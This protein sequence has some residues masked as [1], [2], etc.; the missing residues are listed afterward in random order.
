MDTKT[1]VIATNGRLKWRVQANR[2]QC[3]AMNIPFDQHGFMHLVTRH[4]RETGRPFRASHPRDL[5]RQL[6]GLA[7]YLNVAP[8]LT[9]QLLDAACATYFVKTK[10]SGSG[11]KNPNSPAVL[12]REP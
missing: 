2:G 3:K 12:T 7:R 10:G 8:E 4:Y 6:L 9:P 11:G 5:L 1:F